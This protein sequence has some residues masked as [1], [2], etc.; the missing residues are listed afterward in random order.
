VDRGVD[1]MTRWTING[2]GD[3]GTLAIHITGSGKILEYNVQRMPAGY[4]LSEVEY[5]DGSRLQINASERSEA[6][7]HARCEYHASVFS[8]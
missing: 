6:G 3:T 5:A 7:A 2:R 1:L 8:C 4:W